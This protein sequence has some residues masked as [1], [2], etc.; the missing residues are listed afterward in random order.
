ME[1]FWGR[2]AV[3]TL[4]AVRKSRVV[5]AYQ[6]ECPVK[7]RRISS[8]LAAACLTLSLFAVTAGAQSDEVVAVSGSATGAF[9]EEGEATFGPAPTVELPPEGGGP[10]TD[11][12]GL[13]GADLYV[14]TEGAL[15]ADGFVASF[16]SLDA[17]EGG[18]VESECYA[19]ADGAEGST[20]ISLFDLPE[21]PAPN[22]PF[23]LDLGGGT[24]VTGIA[25]QQVPSADGLAIFVTGLVYEVTDEVGAV[26]QTGVF[27]EVEC[28]VTLAGDPTPPTP[29]EPAA[30]ARVEPRFTG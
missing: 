29:P 15:G 1:A 23:E 17:G 28:G 27:A 24:T 6:E 4:R 20:F 21:S 19:D 10:L 14:E 12:D 11:T 16:A 9:Y 13:E 26:L 5:G 22:T 18:Y 30:A 7:I 2:A 8:V 25:N 3:A